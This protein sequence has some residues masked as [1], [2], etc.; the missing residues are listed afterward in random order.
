MPVHHSPHHNDAYPLQE[1][2]SD[3]ATF[4]S[5]YYLA[6]ESLSA[7]EPQNGEKLKKN[8][9]KDMHVRLIGVV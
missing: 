7:I 4:S 5:F 2:S 3:Q 9:R 1:Q 8:Q 6:F